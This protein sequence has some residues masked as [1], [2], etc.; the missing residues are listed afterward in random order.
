MPI[1]R[2]YWF[3]VR[4]FLLIYNIYLKLRCFQGSLF[5]IWLFPGITDFTRHGF[6]DIRKCQF[7]HVNMTAFLCMH[8]CFKNLTD[9]FF[10]S[11]FNVS[12][13]KHVVKCFL[14]LK[15]PGERKTTRKKTEKQYPRI[16]PFVSCVLVC[17]PNTLRS[18]WWQQ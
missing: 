7:Q 17:P 12:Y 3:W 2:A 4:S 11:W 1:R 16:M 6:L 5:C 14:F 8:N 15:A 18:A 10:V 13:I 9:F